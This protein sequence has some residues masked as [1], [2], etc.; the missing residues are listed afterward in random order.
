M[1]N[2]TIST[3]EST[4]LPSN[5]VQSGRYTISVCLTCHTI[6]KVW[7]DYIGTMV[8]GESLRNHNHDLVFA[9]NK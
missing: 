8:V 6:T 3:V 2:R 9:D 1:V 5:T 4:F 7:D